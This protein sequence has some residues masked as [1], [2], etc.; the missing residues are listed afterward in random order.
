MFIECI[1]K[2]FTSTNVQ[3]IYK[4]PVLLTL[5]LE[6]SSW[7]CLFLT[8]DKARCYSKTL[9]LS[10]C[11]LQWNLLFCLLIL[12]FNCHIFVYNFWKINLNSF[13][14]F[15]TSIGHCKPVS[16][17]IIKFS[18]LRDLNF[19]ARLYTS[20][21]MYKSK[22]QNIVLWKSDCLRSRLS[23]TASKIKLAFLTASSRV[24]DNNNSSFW[25]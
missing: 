23:G 25:N 16:L 24:V 22:N 4:T 6:L 2:K 15:W 17:D 8:D 14:L 13:C 9:L 1:L 11:C 3:K 12:I 21:Y 19:L 7:F 5:K 10:I 20:I 18:R